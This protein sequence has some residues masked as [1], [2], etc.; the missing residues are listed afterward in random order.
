MP[1]HLGRRVMPSGCRQGS[2]RLR[3]FA[4]PV[5]TFPP[6][7]FHAGLGDRAEVDVHPFASAAAL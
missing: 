4:V 2:D 1:V 6:E 5:R 7:V 3:W